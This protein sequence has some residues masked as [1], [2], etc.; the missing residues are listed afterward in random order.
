MGKRRTRDETRIARERV[1]QTA[2]SLAA[3]EGYDAT[4]IAQVSAGAGESESFI[5][6]HFQN[7]DALL[8]EAL[9]HGHSS[10][11]ERL[12]GW[13]D[14]PAP[15]H[16]L[17]A[18]GDKFSSTSREGTLGSAYLRFGLN[19]ALQRR[20]QPPSARQRFLD[21]RAEALTRITNWWMHSLDPG[22][23][24]RS[25]GV[26]RFMAHLT[27]A[28][29][30]GSFLSLLGTEQSTRVTDAILSA[31]LH[32]IACSFETG[33]AELP[34]NSRVAPAPGPDPRNLTG[35]DALIEAAI[36]VCAAGGTE[37]ATVARICD[38]AGLPASSLYWFFEDK[39]ALL[40][41]ASTEVV[42]RWNHSA[43]TD[44]TG[45]PIR[46]LDASALRE[47]S[48]LPQLL[49]LSALTRLQGNASAE[50]A[51][52]PLDEWRTRMT[53][54]YAKVWADQVPHYLVH[55]VRRILTTEAA[56]AR[57]ILLDGLFLT[58][59]IDHQYQD[60]AQ[61][62]WVIGQTMQTALVA[63][64]ALAAAAHRANLIEQRA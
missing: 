48:R 29:S 55:D 6:W 5:I 16:R 37:F 21:L 57:L 27:V 40:E 56:T 7:K 43:T 38:T 1:L 39:E 62:E 36:E 24:E 31:A 4:T 3:S 45:D 20:D 64:T 50:R 47:I 15:G 35:R 44:V 54:E 26:S 10:R 8:S 49:Q 25:P 33:R 41:A 28:A 59:H 53:E 18:L 42:N 17:Q 23:V 9:A 14:R 51:R 19:L 11:R 22:L 60:L 52:A 58:A 34:S 30:D 12:A 13:L 61:L 32:E 2:I 63:P 46:E